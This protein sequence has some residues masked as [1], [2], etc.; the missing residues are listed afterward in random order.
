MFAESVH[1]TFQDGKEKENSEFALVHLRRCATAMYERQEIVPLLQGK[2]DG[3]DDTGL[4]TSCER[5]RFAESNFGQ[6]TL[7]LVA[8][9]LPD[10]SEQQNGLDS[11]RWAT[12][13][14]VIFKLSRGL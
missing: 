10:V 1:G 11:V 8:F 5:A 7:D 4:R 3:G 9:W 14:H 13:V 2:L 12:R 6:T